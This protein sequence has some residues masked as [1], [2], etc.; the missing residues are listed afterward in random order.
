V[1]GPILRALAL[2]GL[3]VLLAVPLFVAGAYFKFLLILVFIYSIVAIGLNILV[4][5]AGQF[6]LGHAALMAVGAYGSALISI[7]LESIP[8]L[9]ASGANV[10]IGMV[11]GS[12]AAGLAGAALAFPALRLK[13][14]YLAMVTVAFGW[15]T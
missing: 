14:P 10:W 3:A 11:V 7:S 9:A 6:S 4:G 2:I 8:V 5:Y 12:L 1:S 15:M 13:G